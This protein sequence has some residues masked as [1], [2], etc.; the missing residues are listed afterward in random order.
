MTRRVPKRAPV[1]HVESIQRGSEP[2][3]VNGVSGPARMPTRREV[4]AAQLKATKRGSKTQVVGDQALWSQAARIGGGLTP[5]QLSNIIT[6]ANAGYP[7]RLVDLANE[8][9]QRDCHLQAV[10]SVNEESIAGLE[11]NIT[12]PDKARAKDK[13]AAKWIEDTLRK[14]PELPRLIADLVGAT[15]QGYAALEIIWRKED[16]K[17]IPDCFKL[18]PQ[19]R[20]RFRKIDGKLVLCDETTAFQEIDL[21]ELASN[22]FIICQPRINGDSANREGLNRPLVWMSMMRNWSIG[23]WLKTGEMSWKPWRVGTYKKGGGTSA[24]DR[25]I[26]ETVMRKLTTDYSA[27]IPD[28]CEIEINWPGGTSH[29]GSTHAEIVNTLGNEMS[30][31]VLG[32][33][34]TTQAS[35][36]SGYAQSKVHDSIRKDL[37]ESRARQVAA[38]LTKY[39]VGAMYVLNYGTT[40]EQGTFKFAT[41]DPINL[42]EFSDAIGGLKTAGARIPETWLHEQAGIPIPEDGE[43]LLGNTAAGP[44]PEPG[45]PG[46]PLP[47]GATP[48]AL[49]PGQSPPGNK[50]GAPA[51]GDKPAAE[52]EK[53][54]GKAPAAKE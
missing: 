52:P 13:R 6:E 4:R 1:P 51:A 49:A 7:T 42:K 17:Q 31:C 19:R 39:L 48:P 12:P 32:Q 28:S 15:Y 18:I 37:R 29:T 44:I 47:P 30:K 38:S 10:L 24:E 9:R 53:K 26:L 35:S 2:K 21:E 23:D 46:A 8:C 34:E 3:H 41:Q 14:N 50:P 45:T 43:R 27:V 20:F 40:V 33:T 22:K 16:G 25:A 11:W 54:P 36:S 5:P